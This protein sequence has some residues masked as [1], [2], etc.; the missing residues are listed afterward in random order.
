VALMAAL[1][2]ARRLSALRTAITGRRSD[3]SDARQWGTGSSYAG[4]QYSRMVAGWFAQL[5]DPNLELRY[6]LY[7][8]RA[9]SRELVRDNGE[10]AGVLLDFESDIVGAQGARLQFRARTP[11]GLP[12]DVLNS[13]IETA[14]AT[15]CRRDTCTT[16]GAFDFASLQRLM[17]RSVVCDGEFVALRVRD[18]RHPFGYALKPIDPDQL[19]EKYNVLRNAD[20]IAIEMGVENDRDGR[21]IAYHIWDRHPLLPGRTRERIAAADVLH[22]FKRLRPAQMRGVPWFAPALVAWKLGDRYTEAE[23]YQSLL[24]AAQ[25]GFFVNKSG[26]GGFELPRDASGQPVP[27]VMEAEPGASRV[28]PNGYEF[29]PWQPTHPTAN[30]VGFMKSVKRGIS[31]A[32]GRSYATLTGDLSDVN[33]SSMRTDRIRETEQNKL[34]QADLLTSQFCDPIFT[35]WLRAALLAGAL[36]PVTVDLGVLRTFATWMCKGWPWIDPMKD[37]SAATMA[38]AQG[39]TSRQTLCAERGVDFYEIIDQLAEEAAYAQEKGVAL[40]EADVVALT[41][42]TDAAD[43]AD[44]ADATDAADGTTPADASATSE[45][46]PTTGRGAALRIA[47]GA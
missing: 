26:D 15:W 18:P 16:S 44:A 36:G 27:L 10:A 38:L 1:S 9:R 43:A 3:D 6:S 11:R 24:A 21:P 25:G 7:N 40:G 34:H 4:G 31:R 22:V 47:R 8:L 37:I 30:Y 14:W 5:N 42:A 32:F 2:V 35:D 13:R 41:A 28:L 23:L 12:R 20:G 45:A 46:P 33:F 29:Q 17:I 19:D 39:L